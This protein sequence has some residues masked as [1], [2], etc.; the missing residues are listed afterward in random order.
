[1]IAACFEHQT[2]DAFGREAIA[3]VP[4]PTNLC[5]GR[6]DEPVST[7]PVIPEEPMG[8]PDA[9]RIDAPVIIVGVA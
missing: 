5:Y 2:P 1:M 9:V 7:A 3:D 8:N 6:T 4:V